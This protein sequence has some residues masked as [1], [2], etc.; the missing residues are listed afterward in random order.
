[1]ED[2]IDAVARLQLARALVASGDTARG[3]VAYQDFLTLWEKADA[4]VP[5]LKQAF[6]EAAKLR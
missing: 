5:I 6:A 4:D 2:P 3:R 1:M